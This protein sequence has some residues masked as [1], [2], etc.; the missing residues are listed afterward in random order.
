MAELIERNASALLLYNDRGGVLLQHRTADAPRYP[1]LWGFFGGGIEENESPREALIREAREE[2]EYIP[3][4]PEY[5]SETNITTDAS[6]GTIY[7]F[8]E[9]IDVS[10]T[11]IQH[12]GQGM[13]WFNPLNLEALPIIPH[14]K[15]II[16]SAGTAFVQRGILKSID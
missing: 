4:N 7:L 2:L 11:L 14:D 6:K 15:S 13:G 8:I 12:E 9:E 1:N 10:Q 16:E 5:F 3:E